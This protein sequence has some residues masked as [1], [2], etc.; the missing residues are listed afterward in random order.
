[1]QIKNVPDMAYSGQNRSAIQGTEE[2][3]IFFGERSLRNALGQFLLHDHGERNHQ[4]LGNN[5]IEL[6]EEV[7]LACWKLQCRQRLGGM[8]RY[9]YR[10]AA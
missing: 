2:E 7:G 5:I 6:G 3:V 8:L 4:G 1:M 10:S 9:S